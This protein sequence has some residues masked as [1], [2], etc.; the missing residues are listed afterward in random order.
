[1]R[2]AARRRRRRRR[3]PRFAGKIIHWRE[4]IKRWK[5]A[6]KPVRSDEEVARLVVVCQACDHYKPKW[7]QCGLCGC[8]CRGRGRAEFDKPRM[9]TETCPKDLW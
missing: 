2:T 1:M 4:S 9:E 8:F 5:A 6:G 7:K 3:E